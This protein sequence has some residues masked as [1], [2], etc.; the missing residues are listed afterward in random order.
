MFD[1]YKGFRR[2]RW[3]SL[4]LVV[5]RKVGS[6][7]LFCLFCLLWVVTV[8]CVA[9]S[10]AGGSTADG[11]FGS[12]MLYARPSST[13]GVPGLSMWFASLLDERWWGVVCI[14]PIPV[15]LLEFL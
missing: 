4:L 15:P 6:L 12:T 11:R 14:V 3:Q 7:R 13:M 10:G 8:F 1:V 9:E 5:I 2:N